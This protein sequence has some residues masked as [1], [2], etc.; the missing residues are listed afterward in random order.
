[1]LTNVIDRRTRK[2]R[3]KKIN[4]VIEPTRHANRCED[5]DRAKPY[6]KQ[7][8][9]WIGCAADR[10]HIT[11]SEAIA[12]ANAHQDEVTLYLYDKDGGIV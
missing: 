1:M 7:D 4:A 12:W 6:R 11:V 9:A 3:W 10:K 2:Y 5:A 8:G